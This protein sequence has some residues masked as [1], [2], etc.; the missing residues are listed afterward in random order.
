[1]SLPH[2]DMKLLTKL[3]VALLIILIGFA[4]VRSC[5]SGIFSRP[6]IDTVRVVDT[7]WQKK[8]S[9]IVKKVKIKQVIH[10][11][12]E[13]NNYQ[14]HE[15]YDSLKAQYLVLASLYTN[16]NLYQDSLQIPEIKG[17]IIIKDTLQKNLILGRG[18]DISY[19]L[20]TVKETL[21]ITKTNPPK[22]MLFGGL[23]TNVMVMHPQINLGLLY[24]DRKNRMYGGF[25]VLDPMN[26]NITYGV[27]AYWK[28][29]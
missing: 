11:T 21:T 2:D 26:G 5:D 14:P 23:G 6:Q 3:V 20:P 25:A 4:G 8:D 15:D 27:Q 28:L 18:F 19:S 17:L 12:V 9:I 16:K 29:F 10:D 13:L 22:R 7:I 1:M 24:K